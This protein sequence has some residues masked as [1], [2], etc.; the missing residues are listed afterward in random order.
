MNDSH[1]SQTVV[2]VDVGG[3]FTDFV[4]ID[5]EG[6][7][8]VRKFPSTPAAPESSVLAGLQDARQSKFLT[9]KFALI[10]GTTVATNALLERRGAKTALL[11]TAGHRDILEIARQSRTELYTFHPRK[12]TPILPRTD[13]CEIPERLDWQG[14]VITPLDMNAVEFL[15]L[16]L[17][18][19]GYES[20]AVCL[21]FAYLNPIHEQTIGKRARHLGFAVSL[22]SGIAPEPREY[23][24]ATTTVAN[25]FVSPVMRGYLGRLASEV[26]QLGANSFHIMQSNGGTLSA[27][28]A[29]EYA[30]QT[31]VSGPAG[32]VIA[33][34]QLGKQA[35]YCDLLTFDMGGTSTDVALI[36]NGACEIVTLSIL[37]EIPLRVPM[38]AIHT[39]GAGGGSLAWQDMAGGLRVGPQSAG[40]DPGP[41]AYGKGTQITVT[42]ANLL[43][44]RLPSATVLAGRLPLDLARV[45][46]A[47]DAFAPQFGLSPTEA[48]LGILAV[49]NA[50]MSR[51]LR[52][53]SVERG[54]DPSAFTLLSFGGAGGLHACALAESLQM[55]TVLVPPCPGAFSA[56]GLA[57]ADTRRDYVQA[58]PALP[59]TA[60]TL[61]TLLAHFTALKDRADTEFSSAND[62][63]VMRREVF[64]LE[65]RYRGQSFELRVP[66]EIDTIPA[67]MTTAFHSAHKARYGYADTQ[68]PV[69]IVAA[70]LTVTIANN[71]PF[72]RISLP[73]NA[74]KPFG[75]S[76]VHFDT[77]THRT[78][79]YTRESIAAGQ[80]LETP[81]IVLQMDATTLIPPEWSAQADS[82]GNLILTRE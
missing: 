73:P 60:D 31:A 79:L 10:H 55:R 40:A 57:L 17:K 68:E 49:A 72:P 8:I 22:S 65:M 63:S 46:S 33:A 66:V 52:H 28:E 62:V 78:A 32:G 51:A 30:I 19:D 15:L 36:R 39:V 74:G 75:F 70:R 20:L 45:Q 71:R 11:V 77:G 4:F 18:R 21:L 59:C 6:T 38:C 13:C 7:L 56:L 64:A 29:A 44:N 41:V 34:I 50:A 23:E 27:D 26:K 81:A 24:R 47:F 16:Q 67:A 3:T 58:F 12:S 9:A 69:E 54:V 48:A 25:A 43:L 14:S 35:G 53:I 61:P 80:T 5:S 2:G 37:N 76:D 82:F 1:S 42:D